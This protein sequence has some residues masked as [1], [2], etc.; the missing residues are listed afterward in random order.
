MYKVSVEGSNVI[1]SH[2]ANQLKVKAIILPTSN[3]TNSNSSTNTDNSTEAP[4]PVPVPPTL[5]RLTRIRRP[6]NCGVLHLRGEELWY[7]NT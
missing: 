3:S 2:H 5:R 4:V 1:W 6:E 7:M